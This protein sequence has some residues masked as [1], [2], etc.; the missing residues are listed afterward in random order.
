CY[1]DRMDTA[2]AA[3]D[4]A[5][6]RAGAGTVAELAVTGLPAVLVPYPFATGDHQRENA[7]ELTEA[8]GAVVVADADATEERLG[9]LLDEL[10]DDR[11]RLAAM[12]AAA[13]S[14]ARPRAADELAS[15]A[16]ELA[17]GGAR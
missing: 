8:G 15:W 1:L 11:D 2:Y 13:R 7:A 10:V 16:L 12:A 6:C 9:P 14:V 5:L 4:A 17:G 3:A